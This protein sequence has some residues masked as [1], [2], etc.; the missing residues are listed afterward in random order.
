MSQFQDS[1]IHSILKK[2]VFE[3]QFFLNVFV[4]GGPKVKRI[5][6]RR[7]IDISQVHCF[8]VDKRSVDIEEVW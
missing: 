8:L 1:G 6:I 5:R 7:D 4:F 3:F 2:H